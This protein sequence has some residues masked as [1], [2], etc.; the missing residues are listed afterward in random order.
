MPH[1][2]V[3]A[4]VVARVGGSRF[5]GVRPYPQARRAGRQP[6]GLGAL[7]LVT[8]ALRA[9]GLRSLVL[10]SSSRGTSVRRV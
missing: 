8:V 4:T 5:P 3:D 7:R 9:T 1:A 6:R 10:C 2:R